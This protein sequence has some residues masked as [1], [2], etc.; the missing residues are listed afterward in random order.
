MRLTHQDN[1]R[2]QK[3]QEIP[4]PQRWKRWASALMVSGLLLVG[5]KV[6]SAKDTCSVKRKQGTMQQFSVVKS[7]KKRIKSMRLNIPELH[8]GRYIQINIPPA[9]ANKVIKESLKAD[10]SKRLELFRTVMGANI[11]KGLAALGTRKSKSFT[12][13][14]FEIPTV[15]QPKGLPEL[16]KQI[17]R[18]KGTKDNPY[19]VYPNKVKRA[20]SG[21]GS[22]IIEKAPF[23]FSAEGAPVKVYFKVT[24]SLNQLKGEARE[25]TAFELGTIIRQATDRRLMEERGMVGGKVSVNIYPGINSIIKKASAKSKEIE[26]YFKTEP[27]SEPGKTRRRTLDLDKK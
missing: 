15:K 13:A 20:T 14:S 17:K 2:T 6:A 4:K 8:E 24:L 18:G 9:Y 16:P 5:A 27:E 22:T 1:V 21:V 19:I 25:A 26:K 7:H 23:V 12:C 11:D 10:E 3:R